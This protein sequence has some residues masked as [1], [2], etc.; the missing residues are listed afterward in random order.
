MEKIKIY[1]LAALGF[2]SAVFAALFYREK[3]NHQEALKEGLEAARD[4]EN[5]ATDALIEGI[6]DEQKII[7][8]GTAPDRDYFDK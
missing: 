1:A 3:A 7:S 5:K 6:S 4:T 8:D 2:L